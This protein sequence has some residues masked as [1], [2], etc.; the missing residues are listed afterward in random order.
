MCMDTFTI[1]SKIRAS[2]GSKFVL[3]PSQIAN[4]MEL[5]DGDTATL[6][7]LGAREIKVKFG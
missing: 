5:K 7:I 3:I 1:Q 2:G 4:A 6:E